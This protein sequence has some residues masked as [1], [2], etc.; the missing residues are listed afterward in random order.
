MKSTRKSSPSPSSRRGTQLRFR[1]AF[2]SFAEEMEHTYLLLRTRRIGFKENNRRLGQETHCE[3]KRRTERDEVALCVFRN[4][5]LPW[6]WGFSGPHELIACRVTRATAR[7]ALQSKYPPAQFRAAYFCVALLWSTPVRF[8]ADFNLT[9]CRL[10]TAW[11]G[12][13]GL[14]PPLCECW[15]PGG[16]IVK[17]EH[18]PFGVS[19]YPFKKLTQTM[20]GGGAAVSVTSTLSVWPQV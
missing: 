1:A 20:A 13:A 2:R 14:M 17:A 18:L 7:F 9:V 4:I 6:L 16:R 15:G 3:A 11:S 10:V 19:L 5:L 12:R 8:K